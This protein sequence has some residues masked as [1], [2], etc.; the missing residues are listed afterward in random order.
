MVNVLYVEDNE[1]DVMLFEMSWDRYCRDLQVH[2][3]TV[4][5]VR[6]ANEY[7]K[8]RQYKA[9]ILD[10][11]LPDGTCL[12]IAH[13]IRQSNQ[14]IAMV[15]LSGMVTDEIKAKA[16]PYNPSCILEKDYSKAHMQKILQLLQGL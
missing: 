10:W 2:F 15:L 3:D 16:A 12:D 14:N 5:T 13:N 1:G 11:N 9:V 4:E 7:L 6:V 8:T